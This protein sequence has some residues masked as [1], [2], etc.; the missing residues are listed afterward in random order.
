[1]ALVALAA[2]MR[3]G[4]VGFI[5]HPERQVV[6]LRPA[7]IDWT[8]LMEWVVQTPPGTHLLADP[9]HAW[10]HGASVRATSQR[11]VFLEEVKDP[12]LA[13]Y[14][15][16]VAQHVLDR[17]HDLGEFGT[18]TAERATVLADKY[19]PHYL[20]TDRSFELPLAHQVGPF[21]AYRPPASVHTA[22]RRSG[23]PALAA[24]AVS[25]LF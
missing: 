15:K 6:A 23:R 18:L 16:A 3:G 5:E 25:C 10:R 8:R 14:S 7:E 17:L 1:V 9:A 22:R 12:A 19:D 20:L 4:Y 21:R 11:D 2:V 24:N 13:I